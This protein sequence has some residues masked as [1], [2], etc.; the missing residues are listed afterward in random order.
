MESTAQPDQSVSLESWGSA[1][2]EELLVQGALRIPPKELAN[3]PIEVSLSFLVSAAR[4]DGRIEA[5]LVRTGAAPTLISV[6]VS[7]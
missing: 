5:R 3:G 6:D 7:D 4:D 1:V 2:L